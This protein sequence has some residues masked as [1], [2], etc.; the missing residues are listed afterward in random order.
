VFDWAS[1][2]A[3]ARADVLA[4]G[5]RLSPWLAAQSRIADRLV[6]RTIRES[7]GG[8]FRFAVSGG[9]PLGDTLARWFYGIGLPL[10]EGYGLT[11]TSPV[12]TVVPLH[13]LRFGTVG[14]PLPNVE[15]RIAD[16]GEVL[17][18]GPN[19]MMGYYGRPA[20]T[21][22][23]LRDGWLC[24]GDIGQ[25][26]ER[27]YLRIT[28]R[29]KELLVTSG[30]KKIAPQPIEERLRRQELI[31]EAVLIGDKRRFAAALIVP[32]FRT[33][34]ARLGA[35]VPAGAADMA[36]LLTRPDVHAL[37]A[38]AIEDVN[39]GLAHFE[40]IKAFRLLPREFT[41]D[42]GELTPTM[43][44]KRRVID[45]NYRTEIEAMYESN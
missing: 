3:L 9:A 42:A 31:S 25:L 13:A 39:A 34:A 23:A 33:L 7:L 29:K 27:G 19:V 35:A 17:T 28:D 18:R 14:P 2:V 22:A 40:R 15:V 12:V 43:K 45:A 41:Q 11:E 4:A 37:Y 5:R 26:D 30:G 21:A 8:R 32:E 38:A 6:F 20:E 1:G 24:T 44:V 10:I 36:A 16:D